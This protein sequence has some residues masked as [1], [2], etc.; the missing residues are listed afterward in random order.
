MPKPDHQPMTREAFWE[1]ALTGGVGA[2]FDW[3]AAATVLA[4]I[5][6]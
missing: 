6:S 4:P 1:R 5:K 3:L 2:Q